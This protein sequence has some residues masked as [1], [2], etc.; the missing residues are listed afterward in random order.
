MQQSQCKPSAEPNCSRFAEV[1][2][3]F[4]V[5]DGKGTQKTRNYFDNN[6]GSSFTFYRKSRLSECRIPYQRLSFEYIPRSGRR[7]GTCS[8]ATAASFFFVCLRLGCPL[9]G[10]ALDGCCYLVGRAIVER[11]SYAAQL[12]VFRIF[13]PSAGAGGRPSAV[14]P[15]RNIQWCQQ[16]IR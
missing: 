8:R 6:Y 14:L 1:Q 11:R 2:P 10:C 4:T 9:Q 5:F 12:Q 16:T 13:G 3:G 7:V 15:V